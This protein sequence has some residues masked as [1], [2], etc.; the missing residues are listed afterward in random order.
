VADEPTTALDV[1]VQDEIVRLLI[2]L[3]KERRMA[4][5]FVTHN[6]GLVKNVADKVAVMNDGQIVERGE[7]NRILKDPEHPYTKGLLSCVLTLKPR[8]GPLRGGPPRGGPPRGGPLPT[9]E[10]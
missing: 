2:K 6:L 8:S 7:T 3:Q 5:I 10:T 1:V 9:L 4:M